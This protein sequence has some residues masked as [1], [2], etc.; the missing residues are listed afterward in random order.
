MADGR[1]RKR[2]LASEALEALEQPQ[3][4]QQSQQPRQQ[5]SQQVT[6]AAVR[7]VRAVTAVT[8]V[9]SHRRLGCARGDCRGEGEKYIAEHRERGD[10]TERV[11]RKRH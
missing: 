4:S 3:Q 9:S 2:R 5:Q 6:A 7:A 8:A 11:Q 1:G 10:I